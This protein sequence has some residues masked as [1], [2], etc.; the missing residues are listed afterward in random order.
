[1]LKRIKELLNRRSRR[2]SAAA[3]ADGAPPTEA[4]KPRVQV[5]PRAVHRPIP[6]SDLDPDAVK[7]VHRLT[8]F[9]H[10]AYLVGGCVRDLLLE[11][12]PKD[13]DI[14]TSATPRQIKRL[15]RNSRIIG[16]RFRLA[17]IYF[18]QGKIIEV[19]TFRAL[20]GDDGDDAERAE[21]DLLIREDNQ[22]GT[23]EEDALRRDFTVNALFYD[24]SRETVLDH[25]DGLGD[26]RR[27]LIRTIG[28]PEVRFREDPIR[29]LRAIKFAARLDFEIEAKTLSALQRT[30]QEIPKAAAPRILE[31][32]NRFCRGGEARRSFELLRKH[33]IFE[34]VLPEIARSYR[35]RPESGKILGAL[36]DDIDRLQ[37][38]GR[39]VPT[40]AI[41]AALLLP[42]LYE[43][44][45]WSAD[46]E[47]RPM[48]G[49][50]V[51]ALAD[52]VLRPL[53]VRLRVSRKD[54]ETCR[55]ILLTLFRM[56]PPRRA[57]R[58]TRRSILR[59]ECLPE[60]L[61]ILGSLGRELGGEFPA[62]H[63][64]WVRAAES[65][66]ATPSAPKRSAG[67][68]DSEKPKPAAGGA[69]RK[70]RSRSRRRPEKDG[71]QARPTPSPRKED[72]K[73][74][75]PPWD[76]DYFFAAL[77]SVP[78]MKGE[79]KQG[80]RYGAAAVAPSPEPAEEDEAQKA[81]DGGDRPKRK[82]RPRRRRRRPSG[83]A[84][85]SNGKNDGEGGGSEG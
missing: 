9:D 8:R 39:E 45:G 30:R 42:A 48:K 26:L 72:G 73:E 34:I 11:R 12:K 82:R 74:M 25:A 41:F 76:D 24:I 55:Q 63:E 64:H 79:D 21:N 35:E 65:A 23:P 31:E 2:P 46:G 20:N 32:I 60:A 77:P 22:F 81:T 43:E 14:G 52:P 37:A 83:T 15:F 56:V 62:A 57:R 40:G 29:I 36:L 78:N 54:Q 6:R 28:D 13:F 71:K 33:G 27:R 3:P 44:L 16:R 66:S 1:M 75:P 69:K 51:R 85:K 70:R 68:A 10:S 80:D 58:N 38:K 18:Q 67:P 7:I 61:W 49:L 84:E 59:R 5:A 47:V 19:A 53:A 50:D 17:H 4:A